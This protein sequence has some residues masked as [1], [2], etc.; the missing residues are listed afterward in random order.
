MLREDDGM[1]R[2]V[3]GVLVLAVCG[4]MVAP[5]AM[6]GGK[7]NGGGGKK[8]TITGD[9]VAGPTNGQWSSGQFA[10]WEVIHVTGAINVNPGGPITINYVPS[11]ISTTNAIVWQTHGEW[12][13]ASKNGNF[14]GL[15]H[16]AT[17]TYYAPRDFDM[18]VNV[19]LSGYKMP[20]G[21]GVTLCIM[22]KMSDFTMGQ[23]V[24]VDVGKTTVSVSG[25][26]LPFDYVDWSTTSQDNAWLL[27]H[28]A[29]HSFTF[30]I[31]K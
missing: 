11:T 29:T 6:A 30:V 18:A 22:M 23:Q 24:R 8:S 19:K 14:V 21:H 3:L 10:Y 25:T 1:K 9:F 12:V 27:Y 20:D 7:P 28:G 4:M 2:V 31:N 17:G 26:S 5:V 15:N 13:A 16:L